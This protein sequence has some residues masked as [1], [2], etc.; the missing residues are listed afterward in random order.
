MKKE[1]KNVARSRAALRDA[2]VRSLNEGMSIEKITVSYLCE[3]AGV[4]RG[5]FYNHYSKVMDLVR[6]IEAYYLSVLSATFEE[7]GVASNDTRIAFFKRVNRV[8]EENH[9]VAVAVTK[10]MPYDFQNDIQANFG[11]TNARFLALC[12][13]GETP[14]KEQ[15][16][17]I[18]IVGRGI[19]SLYCSTIV[20]KTSMTTDEVAEAAVQLLGLID[21]KKN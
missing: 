10:C 6:E 14:T 16:N 7:I 3:K 4:N 8:I 18:E 11:K 17:L 15:Q 2:V 9:S 5:T 21:P 20:G 13:F 12:F 1:Y 19:A